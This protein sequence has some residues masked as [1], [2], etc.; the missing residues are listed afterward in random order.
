M[1][2]FKWNHFT[3][4]ELYII[5]YYISVIYQ[6]AI[7]S[8]MVWKINI[9]LNEVMLERWKII[10]HFEGILVLKK[11]LRYELHRFYSSYIFLTTVYLRKIRTM[12]KQRRKSLLKLERTTKLKRI[13]VNKIQLWDVTSKSD[14]SVW[15]IHYMNFSMYAKN[16]VFI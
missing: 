6:I 10:E 4:L 14:L 2:H 7:S 3:L 5:S 16:V 12:W 11:A 9:F 1:R 8:K 15:I 13:I